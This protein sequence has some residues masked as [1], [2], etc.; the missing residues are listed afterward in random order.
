MASIAK[1]NDRQTNFLKWL[2]QSNSKVKETFEI[3]M[4]DLNVA[5][6]A[7]D[8]IYDDYE[9]LSNDEFWEVL[10]VFSRQVLK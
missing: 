3:N 1:L 7:V 4:C 9:K 6:E 10:Q 2:T 8:P 5:N